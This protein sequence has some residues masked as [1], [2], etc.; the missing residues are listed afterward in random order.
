[1]VSDRDD[2]SLVVDDI[3]HKSFEDLDQLRTELPRETMT[4]LAR[5]VLSRLAGKVK[6]PQA[7]PKT[8][9]ALGKALIDP[10]PDAAAALIEKHFSRGVEIDAIYLDYLAPASERLGEWWTADKVTFAEVTVG[11][12]RI[13]AIMRSLNRRVRPTAQPEQ[14]SAVFAMVPGDDHV[15]GLRMAVDLARK[16]GW[17]IEAHLS[18]EHDTLV[19]EIAASGKLL[20]GLSAG[21]AHAFPDL[22]R[23]IVALRITIPNIKIV[24]SGGILDM[25]DEKIKLLHAD[26]VARTF[27]DAMTQLDRLWQDF[28][29]EEK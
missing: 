16:E 10:D 27:E 4:A 26:A 22:V 28:H 9:S 14:K 18:P 29:A 6:N 23:L 7:D 25:P 1:M 3:Y 11:T 19:D 13:Y 2:T 15:L 17:E 12:G 8:I 24:L 5:E 21:G 20:V